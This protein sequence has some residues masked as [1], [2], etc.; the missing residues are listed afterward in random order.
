MRKKN[1]IERFYDKVWY[2]V[3]KLWIKSKK[4]RRP[5]TFI[6]HDF[7]HKHPAI[8][9]VVQ[10]LIIALFSWWL[11][12]WVLVAM[13]YTFIQGHILWGGHKVGEQENPPY[14][15]YEQDRY[16]ESGKPRIFY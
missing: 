9:T 10:L 4:A 13:L 3:E 14:I 15:E 6:F 11:S 1:W 2:K 7:A 5:F 16:T 8:Y 12:P